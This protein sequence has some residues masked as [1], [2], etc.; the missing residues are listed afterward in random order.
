M[1]MRAEEQKAAIE[2]AERVLKRSGEL[3]IWDCDI[4]TAYPEPFCIDLVIHMPN[5]IVTTTYGIEKMDSQNKDGL[6]Q[7]CV[8]SGLHLV[9][10][11]AGEKHF[12]LKFRKE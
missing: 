10:Q 2:E 5:E 6:T 7:M 11:E 1:F 3:H 4:A 12:Y 9:Y 8:D